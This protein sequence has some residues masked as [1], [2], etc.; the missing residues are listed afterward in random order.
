MR[1]VAII[2]LSALTFAFVMNGE[3][4]AK[5]PNQKTTETDK[6]DP[7]PKSKPKNTLADKNHAKPPPKPTA[8]ELQDM[9]DRAAQKK[10]ELQ[11]KKAEASQGAPLMR[12]HTSGGRRSRSSDSNWLHEK[13]DK[14]F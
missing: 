13:K 8:A 5:E 4:M 10:A 2:L 11:A 9:K 6:K 14:L 1:R 3:A 7:K 12:L